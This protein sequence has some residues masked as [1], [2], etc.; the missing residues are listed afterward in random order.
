VLW[1]DVATSLTCAR[2]PPYSARISIS[3]SSSVFPFDTWVKPALYPSLA[4]CLP[5]SALSTLPK[6]CTTSGNRKPSICI[7]RWNR[8]VFL[9]EAL[10]MIGT[11]CQSK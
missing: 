7:S 6:C 2:I 9:G 1:V 8:F 3:G 11:G 5:V 10:R 4:L